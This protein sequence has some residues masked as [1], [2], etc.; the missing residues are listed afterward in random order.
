MRVPPFELPDHITCVGSKKSQSNEDDKAW[1]QAE[2]GNSSWKGKD[3]ERDGFGH[4]QKT[5]LPDIVHQ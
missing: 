2:T 4:H 1:N 5:S 3:S